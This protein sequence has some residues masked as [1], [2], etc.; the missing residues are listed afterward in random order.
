MSSLLVNVELKLADEEELALI[1]LSPKVR[2]KLR[3]ASPTA[4]AMEQN[5]A[6]QF[7]VEL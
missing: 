5:E 2:P 4:K 7:Q 1:F 3:E 6:E